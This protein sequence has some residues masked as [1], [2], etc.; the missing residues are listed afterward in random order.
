M[1]GAFFVEQ[2]KWRKP[3]GSK[4][5]G[6]RGRT[7]GRKLLLCKGLGESFILYL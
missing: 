6:R 7:S 5:L 2:K 4:D 1:G 3:F